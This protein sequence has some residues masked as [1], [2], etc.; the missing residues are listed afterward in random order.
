L[1]ILFTSTYNYI[2]LSRKAIIKFVI[3]VYFK[4][5]S[6]WQLL[7]TMFG[8]ITIKLLHTLN[9]T[10]TVSINSVK[11]PQRHI[12]HLLCDNLFFTSVTFLGFYFMILCSL[13]NDFPVF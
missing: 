8:F 7:I 4:E 12:F 9:I 2:Y 10:I 11:I 1:T 13:N 3:T 6:T 5:F